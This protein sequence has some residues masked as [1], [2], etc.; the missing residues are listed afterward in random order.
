MSNYIIDKHSKSVIWING[1]PNQLD[2]K[3]AWSNFDPANHEIVYATGYNPQ[4]GD[5]FKAEVADGCVKDFKPKKIYNKVSGAERVLQTWED[6]IDP[7]IETEEAPLQGKDGQNL[8]DQ[9]YT[10]SGWRIDL[11][12]KKE[13]LLRSLQSICESKIVSGFYSSALGAPY[14]YGSDRDDQLNLIGSV[15]LN[16]NVPYKCA[17]SDGFKEYRIHTAEQI[18]RV[19]NDG[20]IRKIFLL[21]RAGE[22][23]T[24]IQEAS[25]WEELST[26]DTD[27]GWE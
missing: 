3:S 16:V 10:P 6:E 13:S 14:Y 12:L 23:K 26:I 24:R 25:S 17:G 9:I 27:A 7:E 11:D 15:S 18:K 1:D 21:Q 4:I 8:P 5:Q 19:L 22:L 20:A 2:G